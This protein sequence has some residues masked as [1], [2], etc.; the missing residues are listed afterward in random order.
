[1][2]QYNAMQCNTMQCNT[3]THTYALEH[4]DSIAQWLDIC[5]WECTCD[6]IQLTRPTS[7]H[8]SSR[9]RMSSHHT[10]SRDFATIRQNVHA[11]Q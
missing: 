6:P 4:L 5:A 7:H 11:I 10:I 8:M 2:Q 3:I 9:Y 1:M